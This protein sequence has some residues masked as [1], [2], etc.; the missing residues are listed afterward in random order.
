MKVWLSP[1]ATGTEKTT[2]GVAPKF[3]E[4]PI[5]SG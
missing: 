5:A 2:I 1:D 4:L 3:C